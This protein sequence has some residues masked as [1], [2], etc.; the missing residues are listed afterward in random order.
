M[1]DGV[2][3]FFLFWLPAY[4]KAVYGMTGTTIAFPIAVLYTMTCVGSIGGGAFPMYFIRKG[5]EPYAGRMRA[6]LVIALFPLVVLLAQPLGGISYW[7][8]VILIGIGASAH[9]AWSANIFTTVSDMFPK[10]S[11]ASVTGIGGM[12]GGI[13]GIVVTK[14]GGWLFDAYRK[15]GIADFWEKVTNSELAEF[16]E[17]IKSVSLLNRHG[18]VI[19]L[20]VKELVDLPKEAVL[21]IQSGSSLSIDQIKEFG[22]MSREVF[23]E[24]TKTLT[25]PALVEQFEK[26]VEFQKPIVQNQMSISY[27]IMFAFCAVA[28]LIA[29]TVMKSLVPKHKPITDL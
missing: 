22:M 16:A 28:Y 14:A 10:K 18:K 4:L 8:P 26:L 19:D 17:K 2:W 5:Y 7:L 15:T 23:A 25:D 11:V 27:S 1:T 9:Q 20:N 6:M 3:W 13:S 21:Q 24:A 12:A 29:W